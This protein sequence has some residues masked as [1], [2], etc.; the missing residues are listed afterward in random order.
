MKVG[1]HHLTYCTNIHT[2]ESWKEVFASLK[3]TVPELKFNLAPDKPFGIGLRLSN[4]ASREILK[5][6]HLSEFKTWLRKNNLYVFTING[7]PYGDFH[8]SVV[9]D[10]VH[11]PDWTTMERYEYTDRL[12]TIL[13]MI[14]P[15]GM[16]GGV[17]TS[18]VSY[19]P[20]L[21]TKGLDRSIVLKAA[22]IHM[23]MQ[24]EKLYKIK[25]KSGT[26]LHLDIEP[27]PDG[28][29]EN[30]VDVIDYFNDWLLKTGAEFL[31]E[32][33]KISIQEAQHAMLDHVRVCY[34]VCHFALA[35]ERP[36][37]VFEKLRSAGIKIG[38]IQIS[39]ALKVNLVNGVTRDRIA[40]ELVP[41]NESTYLHQVVEKRSDNTYIHY[42][43]LPEA[44]QHIDIPAAE[45]WR[46]HFHVPVFIS[47]YNV[48]QSTQDQIM[49]VLNQ[50]KKEAFP[51]HLEVETY[52]WEVLPADM[53]LSLIPSIQRELEWVIKHLS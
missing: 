43:D 2:G 24:V 25:E 5:D 34:D 38:K 53:Q 9:K 45:E 47:Q 22:T 46:I 10:A 13:K 36:A 27:E 40:E 11:K 42:A 26:V 14:L 49:E 39:A 12:F 51:F 23:A 29:L 3:K 35:Y 32:I 19:R 41:F 30:T 20:W 15:E 37:E 52:T 21:K 31:S 44:L 33:L 48:L 17:S 1:N 4:K 7:F 50:V 28:I 16:E 8:D 6:D 18:P